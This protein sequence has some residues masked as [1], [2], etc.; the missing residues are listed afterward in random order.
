MKNLKI[1]L[2]SLLILCVTTQISVAQT[3]E[4]NNSSS[5]LEVEGTSNIHDW[6]LTT[7][8]Q[9]GKLMA[10]LD[11]GQ[12]VEISKLDFIVKAE[13]LESGKSGMNKNTYKA[14]NTDKYSQIVYRLTKV[15]NIDCTTQGK[16]KVTTIGDLT[17]AG[18]TKPI[19]IT[20]D[21]QVTE[22]QILLTGNKTLNMTEYGIEPPKALF[23]TITT[24]E[25]VNIKFQSY[26][27]K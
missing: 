17:I 13:S 18:T 1:V 26:F 24:G 4:L 16:C 21:A 2:G 9:Q 22:S 3:Y 25:K 8:D 20:F 11:D 14:L 19:N 15:I 5:T 7:E 23:G 10:E 6:E 12:L 27:K